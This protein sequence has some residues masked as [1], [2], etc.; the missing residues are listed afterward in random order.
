MKQVPFHSAVGALL[1]VALCTCP[2]ITYSVSS[3]A[4]F[5]QNPGNIHWSGVKNII[6]YLLH[7]KEMGIS[8]HFR[9]TPCVATDLNP[10][11]W[12]DS[13]FNDTHDGRSTLGYAIFINGFI[14]GWKTKVSSVVTQSSFEAEWIALNVLACEMSWIRDVLSE[15]CNFSFTPS[16]VHTD[17]KA[18]IERM[19]DH[20]VD[21]NKHFQPKYFYVLELVKKEIIFLKKVT[22]D[23]NVADMFTKPLGLPGFN[24]HRNTLCVFV[25]R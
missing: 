16:C 21:S 18:C 20:V 8:Y 24:V 4:R 17:N 5:S 15:M 3:L 23:V 22:S 25:T 2:E 9:Q 13:S 7:I 1:Y 14:I 12:S 19:D 11:G 6:K 10:V